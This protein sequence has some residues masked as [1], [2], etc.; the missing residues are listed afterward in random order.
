MYLGEPTRDIYKGATIHLAMI[1]G[2]A[3]QKVTDEIRQE[4]GLLGSIVR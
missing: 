2:S 1:F 3:I 4:Y